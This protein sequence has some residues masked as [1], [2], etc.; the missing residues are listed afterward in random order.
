[1]K[2]ILTIQDISC[3]GRCSLTVALPIISAMGVETA[4]LPTAVLSTH[5]AFT[6]FTFR[7]LTEDIPG[8]EKAWE[9]EGIRFDAIYSGYLGS[10][11]Q[12]ELVAECWERFGAASGAENRTGA[13]NGKAERSDAARALR[14][15]DP[16]MADNGRLYAGFDEAFVDAMRRLT[17]RADVIVP[18][19][20]EACLLADIPYRESFTDAEYRDLMKRL[21]DH[22]PESVILTGYAN[23]GTDIG[24]LAYR[25]DTD[26]FFSVTGERI[27]VAYHGT[28]DIFASVMVGALA[29][30]LDLE[31]A[32]RL[33]VD[34]DRLCIQ[35]TA[36]DENR[37]WYGV[38]FEEALPW[39]VQQMNGDVK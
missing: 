21:A 15:V 23:S 10:A 29:R 6:H 20:T 12:T 7:D 18:N 27:P 39:L 16:A 1:M 4:V 11:R 31:T 35:K 26:E 14:F 13:M 36:E 3:V 25:R 37:R 32:A 17:S 34:Y 28:G 2:R 22:G 8:I 19:L 33:A 30:G 38:N 24:A 5:T 9:Q